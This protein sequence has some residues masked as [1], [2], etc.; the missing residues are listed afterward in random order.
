[1]MGAVT[2]LAVTF[3]LLGLWSRADRYATVV[4]YHDA[5]LPPLVAS[6]KARPDDQAIALKVE[7]HIRMRD[8][9][10]QAARHPWLPVAPDLP[11]PK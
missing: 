2:I 4:L 11:G 6:Q 1:M 10:L 8:K 9:Y 3:A 7:W 5:A